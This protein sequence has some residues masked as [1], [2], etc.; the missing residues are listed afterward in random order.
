MHAAQQEVHTK[1]G[2]EDGQ[3]G[4]NHIGMIEGGTVEPPDGC[5][6]EWYRIDHQGDE[7]PRLL[8]IPRPVV[9]PRHVGPHGS[10]E[11][12]DGEQEHSG[13]EQKLGEGCELGCLMDEG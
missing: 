8:G 7:G 4:H 9:A 13:V 3:E 5:L 2:D 10:Q 6:V 1:I 12:A 11:D